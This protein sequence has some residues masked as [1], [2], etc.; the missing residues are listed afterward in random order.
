MLSRAHFG[1][2][3]SRQCTLDKTTMGLAQASGQR[4]MTSQMN[5][6]PHPRRPQ[7]IT[8]VHCD[9]VLH[10]TILWET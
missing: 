10:L 1:R 4:P 6:P 3:Q 5:L 7:R 9:G 2:V 8:T